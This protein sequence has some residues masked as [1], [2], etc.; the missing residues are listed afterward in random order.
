[1]LHV[2][3]IVAGAEGDGVLGREDRVKMTGMLSRAERVRRQD[4]R[5]HHMGAAVVRQSVLPCREFARLEENLVLPRDIGGLLKRYI[6]IHELRRRRWLTDT[7]LGGV[8]LHV[9]PPG[10]GKTMAAR[11]VAQGMGTRYARETSRQ[12]VHMEVNLPAIVSD[13]LGETAKRIGVDFGSIAECARRTLT[14]VEIN[15]LESLFFDRAQLPS[16]DPTDLVRAV[17]EL[18][19]QLD[20]LRTCPNFLCTATTNLVGKIDRALIDRADLV[21]HFP[22][23]HVPTGEAIL[24]QAAQEV[25][26][27]DIHVCFREVRAAVERLCAT[28]KAISGRML[29]RLPLMAHLETGARDLQAKDLVRAAR[30]M[31]DREADDA[32]A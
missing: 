8:V 20:R 14:I 22:Y 28:N 10:V 16:G 27:L 29:A 17:N 7:G 12:A 18:L 23:P 11:A 24:G 6:K 19:T 13:M 30:G 26:R 25:E 3:R 2:S 5:G 9:G 31:L 15:E 21:L 1:M 4:A 32:S